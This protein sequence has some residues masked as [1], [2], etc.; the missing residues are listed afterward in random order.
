MHDAKLAKME[1]EMKGVFQV[2]VMEKEG[3]LKQSEEELYARHRE[4]KETLEKQR[5]DLEEKKRR[6][7]S[8]RPLTP[9]RNAVGLNSFPAL[10]TTDDCLADQE[11]GHR[12]PWRTFLNRSL[13]S[14]SALLAQS[15]SVDGFSL[16][17]ASLIMYQSIHRIHSAFIYGKE[18]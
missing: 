10:I 11:K 1:A 9:D 14:T 3:R 16:Y 13:D 5:L 18:Q 15:S 4:M 7:E 17:P 12:L 2:K 6:V 8:G